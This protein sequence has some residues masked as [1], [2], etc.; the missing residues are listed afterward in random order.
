MQAKHA[1]DNHLPSLDPNKEELKTTRS[2][3]QSHS[4]RSVW[5]EVSAGL[6]GSLFS[7]L[8]GRAWHYLQLTGVSENSYHSLLL[9]ATG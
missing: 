7:A 6:K 8:K 4:T 9:V 2:V 1:G 5:R 3:C